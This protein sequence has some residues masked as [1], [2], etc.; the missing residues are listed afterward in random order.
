MYHNHLEL[1]DIV[2]FIIVPCL[3]FKIMVLNVRQLQDGIFDHSI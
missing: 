2:I 1:C 3:E